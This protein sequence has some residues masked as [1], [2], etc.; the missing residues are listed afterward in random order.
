[1]TKNKK[2]DISDRIVL[3]TIGSEYASA[4]NLSFRVEKDIALAEKYLNYVVV[5]WGNSEPVD[6]ADVGEF[7]KVINLSQSIHRNCNKLSALR[8]MS[9]VVAVPRF[10]APGEEVPKG[11]HVYRPK[12]HSGGVGFKVLEAV[13]EVEPGYY[14]TEYIETDIEYRV[15]FCGQATLC[16]RRVPYLDK[17]YKQKFPC[18]STWGYDILRSVPEDLSRQTLL[19]AKAVGLDCGASDILFD[20]KTNKYY[21]LEH[22]TAP[23]CDH[24]KVVKFFNTNLIKLAKKKIL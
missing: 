6:C 24:S 2:F 22:N 20:A 23:S 4:K 8:E 11:K 7:T 18:R 21:F 14:A 17:H 13:G 3:F 5:R 12:Y 9:K 16:A 19:A 1:M 10:Y 15:W